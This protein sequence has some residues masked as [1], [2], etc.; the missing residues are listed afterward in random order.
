LLARN[1]A[2][3]ETLAHKHRVTSNWQ[4][5]HQVIQ[6]LPYTRR[7]IGADVHRKKLVHLVKDETLFWAKAKNHGIY[8][9]RS[10]ARSRQMTIALTGIQNLRKSEVH[11][12]QPT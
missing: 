7:F 8:S 6:S 5:E 11:K 10:R 4:Q 3:D 12:E 9:Y 1:A 2:T